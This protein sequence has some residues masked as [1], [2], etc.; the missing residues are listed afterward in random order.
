MKLWIA[1]D[2]SIIPEDMEHF[3]ERH[4]EKEIEYAR[5]FKHDMHHHYDALMSYASAGETE[6]HRISVGSDR[7]IIRLETERIKFRLERKIQFT[8]MMKL[9]RRRIQRMAHGTACFA[10]H[11]GDG[12]TVRIHFAVMF[13]HIK[14]RN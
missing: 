3:I 11:P 13:A 9:N 6:S 8:V 4:P 5:Q 10:L 2:R 7:I 1:R 12:E 14:Q